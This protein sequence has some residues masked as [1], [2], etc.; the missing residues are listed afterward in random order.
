MF[1]NQRFPDLG[2]WF[3]VGTL[4]QDPLA[5]IETLAP[6]AQKAGIATCL[7][8][9]PGGEHTFQLWSEAFR[10]S[11]PWMAARLGLVRMVPE[12]TEK[13]QKNP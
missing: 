9:V 13:C 11:L 10:D 4:D 6:L 12:M 2:G 3:E 8:L 5:G 1:Q 7:V